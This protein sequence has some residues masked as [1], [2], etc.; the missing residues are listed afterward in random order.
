[1]YLK[2]VGFQSDQT[3]GCKFLVV[4]AASAL[5]RTLHKKTR[6][7]SKSNLPLHLAG[8]HQHWLLN[9]T[10]K[11]HNGEKEHGTKEQD[12]DKERKEHNETHNGTEVWAWGFVNMRILQN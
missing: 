10:N 6:K 2:A 12:D 1:M 9:D 11:E 8:R 7:V 3:I 4:K 5:A